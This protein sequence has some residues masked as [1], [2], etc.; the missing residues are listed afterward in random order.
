MSDGF[1]TWC[2][3]PKNANS[4]HPTVGDRAGRVLRVNSIYYQDYDERKLEYLDDIRKK[5]LMKL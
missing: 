3:G 2:K 1:H 5:K 4:I